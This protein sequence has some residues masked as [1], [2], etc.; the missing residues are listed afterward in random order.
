MKKM[1]LI[2]IFLVT[3]VLKAENTENEKENI[4]NIGN[5]FSANLSTVNI[6]FNRLSLEY[7]ASILKFGLFCG[8]FYPH[9]VYGYS[10]QLYLY[11]KKTFAFAFEAEYFSRA[12]YN[13]LFMADFEWHSKKYY[14][15]LGLG[16][17]LVEFK[18]AC[19]GE[20]YPEDCDIIRPFPLPAFSFKFGYKF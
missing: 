18:D 16:M 3:M 1:F 8:S 20:E 2:F 17:F 15:T 10:L 19:E 13:Y 14:F 9:F 6:G 4:T 7:K 5:H 11:Q 12:G